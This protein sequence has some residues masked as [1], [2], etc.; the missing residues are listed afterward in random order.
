MKGFAANLT[1]SRLEE[2]LAFYMVADPNSSRDETDCRKRE[3][4]T[5]GVKAAD[6]TAERAVPLLR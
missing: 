3:N 2:M 1:A 4:G 5:T 6:H